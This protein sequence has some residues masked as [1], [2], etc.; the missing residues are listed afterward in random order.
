M[1]DDI[2]QPVAQCGDRA[3]QA[4]GK[5]VQGRAQLRGV[6]GVDDAQDRLGPGEV[7]PP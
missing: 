2:E 7:D 1:S 6:L 3:R 5:L 4:A